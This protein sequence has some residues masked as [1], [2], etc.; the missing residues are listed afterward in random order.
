MAFLQELHDANFF[1][2]VFARELFRKV[3]HHSFVVGFVLQ[4]LQQA[5]WRAPASEDIHAAVRI[6][7]HLLNDFSRASDR[8]HV[9]ASGVNHP[10]FELLH[11]ATP[12]HLFVS[13]LENMQ[14]KGCAGQQHHIQRE[15]R[16]PS[17]S[18][19]APRSTT[20]SA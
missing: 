8:R 5:K 14:R 18:H 4:Q 16:N 13:R 11:D 12:D 20:G 1:V 17:R 15:K 2:C 6:L 10:E 3:F 9:L 7:L 19:N